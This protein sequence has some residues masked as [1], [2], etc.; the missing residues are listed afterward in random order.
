MALEYVHCC[1]LKDV[2]DT[3]SDAITNPLGIHQVVMKSV[4]KS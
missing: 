4:L 2:I 3:A 1:S